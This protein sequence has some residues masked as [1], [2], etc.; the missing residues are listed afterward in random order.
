[1]ADDTTPSSPDA[2]LPAPES[3]TF[4]GDGPS[5]SGQPN[6][7]AA[8]PPLGTP[9]AA[10]AAP[11]GAETS[12][13][14]DATATPP[15][16]DMGSTSPYTPLP[17]EIDP[18][19]AQHTQLIA[20][21]SAA[22]IPPFD[23]QAAQMT[24]MVPIVP[25]GDTPAPPLIPEPPALETGIPMVGAGTRVI[26]VISRGAA[27]VPPTSVV[28]VPRIVG[29]V[30]GEALSQ[31][32]Q[33]GLSAQVFNEYAELPQGEVV[34]QLPD[35]GESAPAGSEAVMLV[36]SGPPPEPLAQVPLPDVVGL[37]EADALARLQAAGLAPEIVRDFSANVPL[38]VVVSQLP[39]GHA[40]AEEPKK[41][42]LW[43]LWLLLAFAIIFAVAG[44]AYYWLNRKAVVPNLVGM[45]QSK[46][47]QAI[48][49]AGFKLGSIGTTQTLHASEVGKVT[50]QTPAPN[51]QLKLIGQIDI[52]IAGGQKLVTVPDVTGKPQAEA[53]SVLT[54]AGL[55]V[56]VEQTY[57]ALVATDSVI[58]QS[59]AVGQQVV[60]SSVVTLTVSLGGQNT[61]G[62]GGV[63]PPPLVNPNVPPVATYNIP[64][65]VGKSTSSAKSSISAA[66]MVPGTVTNTLSDTVATGKVISQSPA[67][68]TAAVKGTVI[69][70]TVSSGRP[71][72]VMPSVTGLRK[73]KAATAI[74]GQR[75][76]LLPYVYQWTITATKKDY[77]LFQYPGSS[78]TLKAGTSVL[79]VISNGPMP[80]SA[81]STL[82]PSV[83]G[84][85]KSK[86]AIVLHESNL[87]SY[88]ITWASSSLAAGYVTSQFPSA[89]TRVPLHTQVV[90]I[91]AK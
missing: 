16:A 76:K 75:L 59:P 22:A 84:L 50:T 32:Q 40:I 71:D 68:N 80:E 51:T 23:P 72:P 24:Q 21:A 36:S 82:V 79:N 86:A 69:A 54:S 33:V 19:V 15:G 78:T 11:S 8:E 56:S 18:A 25:A 13:A 77:V 6:P 17:E 28:G 43:W 46:A 57:S 2:D 65:V 88:P 10:A 37:T 53:R 85:G 67:G 14:A 73:D 44:G 38:G 27:I 55:A 58:S 45:S 9:A 35:F 60:G 5:D 62:G 90:V 83:Y 66:G 70:L 29:L 39:N 41:V 89:G 1:M 12:A 52:V 7:A 81:E 49:A 20:P 34:G 31:L 74:K 63:I 42:G 91:V 61:A 87:A 26:I 3:S 30:Q 48:V 64:N 4:F 47:E